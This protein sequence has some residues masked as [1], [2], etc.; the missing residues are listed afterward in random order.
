MKLNQVT[1]S[2]GNSYFVGAGVVHYNDG[3][4]VSGEPVSDALFQIIGGLEVIASLRDADGDSVA[5]GNTYYMECKVLS[6]DYEDLERDV[7]VEVLLPSGLNT[8]GW[9]H[10]SVLQKSIPCSK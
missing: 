6:I 5:V 9:V 7:E 3:W 8:E 2:N 10:S 1:P 4:F